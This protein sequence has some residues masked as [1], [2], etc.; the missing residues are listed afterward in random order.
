MVFVMIRLFDEQPRVVCGD[1][2]Q[3]PVEV[4][5][6]FWCDNWVSVFGRKDYVVVTEVN[7]VAFSSVVLWL[8][9]THYGII[10]R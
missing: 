2:D 1:F 7:T 9:H 6:E 10:A 8:G 4:F 3:F 5:P